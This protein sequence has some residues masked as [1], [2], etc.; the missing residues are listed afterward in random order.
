MGKQERGSTAGGARW[1]R[2]AAVGVVLGCLAGIVQVVAAQA[3]GLLVGRREGA[4]IAPRFV[5][6]TANQ[7]GES[8]SR[9][10]RWFLAT[11]FHFGYAA[12]WGA[13]Y[14]V[15]REARV[16]RQIPPWLGG[17]LLGMLIYALAFSRF[18]AGPQVG[19]ESHPDRRDERE[20]AIH[21]TSAFS[22]ALALAYEDRYLRGR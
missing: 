11:V 6:R 3:V 21:G 22:F 7:F 17:S 4:D 16:S 9:P 14:A 2:D 20:W 10:S 12:G 5:Q 15:S 18:G 8:L 19:S 13:L 1:P